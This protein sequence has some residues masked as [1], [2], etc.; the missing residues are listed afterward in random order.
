M[1]LCL[2]SFRKS[3]YLS[4][5][6]ILRDSAGDSPKDDVGLA[7]SVY[8]LGEALGTNRTGMNVFDV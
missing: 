1:Q 3:A 8:E 7:G 6:L 2:I 4:G 5:S